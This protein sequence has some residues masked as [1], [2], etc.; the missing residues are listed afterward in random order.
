VQ[1]A[2]GIPTFEDKILQR[3][4]VMV[5][6]PVYEQEFLNCSYGYLRLSTTYRSESPDDVR[7]E[8]VGVS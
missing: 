8:P 1:Y 3:A 6:E 4:A 7:C 2:T 5:L